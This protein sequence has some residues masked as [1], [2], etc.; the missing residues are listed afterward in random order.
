MIARRS[1]CLRILQTLSYQ[2]LLWNKCKAWFLSVDEGRTTE[3]TDGR[4]E[5]SQRRIPEKNNRHSFIHLPLCWDWYRCH[6]HRLQQKH[7]FSDIVAV[8]GDDDDDS[9]AD[10]AAGAG[11][12]EVYG[13]FALEMRF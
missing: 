2:T 7:Q 9:G 11:A 12:D 13:C 10:V 1:L 4:K 3:G 8:A 6:R 5:V